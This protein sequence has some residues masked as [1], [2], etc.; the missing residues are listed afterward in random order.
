MCYTCDTNLAQPPHP[1]HICRIHFAITTILKCTNE[2]ISKIFADFNALVI[3]YIQDMI[4]SMLV[5]Q[6]K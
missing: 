5:R 2:L 3:H 4:N 6:F 1:T